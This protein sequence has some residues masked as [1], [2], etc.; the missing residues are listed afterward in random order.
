MARWLIQPEVE[1]KP[2][3]AWHKVKC[4]GIWVRWEWVERK[5]HVETDHDGFHFWYEH[6]FPKE[7]T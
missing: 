5:V 4:D 3:F 7:P 1:W 2:W 6:R